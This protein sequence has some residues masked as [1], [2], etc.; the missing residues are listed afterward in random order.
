MKKKVE[1]NLKRV[2][3]EKGIGKT[4]VFQRKCGRRKKTRVKDTVGR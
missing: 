1:G 2:R 3:R 4:N